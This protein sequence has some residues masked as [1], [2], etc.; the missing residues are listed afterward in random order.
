MGMLDG[1]VAVITGAGSGMAKASVK[2]FVR[3]GA[4]VVAA[5][6]SGAEKDTAAE[7]GDGVLPVHCDVTKEADVE[8]M[9]RA[10][11]DEFGRL[12]AVLQRRRH[13]RRRDAHRRHRWSTTTGTMD[14]DLRGV[15][16]G[17]KHGIRAM[18]ERGNGGAI[19]N[20]SSIGGLNASPFT[21]R[22]LRR[23]GRRDRAHQGRRGRVRRRRASA[24]TPSAPA[25]STPRS[26]ARTLEQMP[27]IAREGG[28]RT[29]AA[30]PHEVAE[31]A[32]VPRVGPRVVRH[33][34]DHPGRRRLGREARVTDAATGAARYAGHARRPRRGRPAAH[35]PRH[36][37]RRHRAAG[38][39]ARVLRA[40]PVRP[41]RDPRDRHVGRARAARRA[42]RV[43]R[44]RPEPRRQ[45][46]V[47]HVDRPR[48]PGDAA[49]AAGRRRGPLRRRPGRAR[50]RREPLPRRGRGRA[51]RRRLRA[52]A[53]RRRLHRRPSTPTRSCTSSHGSNVIGELAGLPAVRA[54]RR[55][56]RRRARRERDDLPAGVRARA[57]GRAR[58]RRR[59]LARDRRAHD[60]RGDAVAA[61][62]AAVLL[63]PAR[64]ARAPHPGRDARH[65]R[66]LRAEGHGPARR[67]VPDARGAEGRRAGE[68][69]RG[70]AREPARRR[71]SRATST[72]TSRW[73]STPTARSRPRT[74]T[75]SPT[76]APTPPRGR[77][78]PAA[79]VGVL[80]PGPYR[81]PR[82]RLR[83]QD[84]LHEHRRP[85]RVPRPV[86]V[87]VAR[88][89]GAARHRGPR[90]WAS[91]RSSCAGATCCAATSCRTRTPTA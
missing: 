6:I 22:V 41:R 49:P 27:G 48:E 44:R 20:W 30:S 63:A 71:A 10:A 38:D 76:A 28:A 13:R 90:R 24:S 57:D 83:D 16:L 37:R 1:K 91:T 43:H 33:R 66:R 36:L 75:S 74:S 19:V 26:W 70:P 69:G 60:L 7:V 73:R 53:R 5:D 65:R 51:R 58:P 21:T 85:H 72:A 78:A 25:S 87:R 17:M 4:K 80:F 12:D 62:G 61:R 52:A 88:P 55:V 46:A 68:V 39:A 79:A 34:R 86:A 45:G 29:A 23:E 56:R 54:R 67:D 82:A 32:R 77:S 11:V 89:R 8:A 81:V 50:R 47:A 14:V 18:L 31:V 40:Q 2:V 15:L 3:E 84:D 42:R 9:M 35:R 59:L 64:D